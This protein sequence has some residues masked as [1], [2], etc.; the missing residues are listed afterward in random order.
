MTQSVDVYKGGL[1]NKKLGSGTATAGSATIA[2]FTS[3]SGNYGADADGP[4]AGQNI[5]VHST[6]GA[7][8]AGK[9]YAARVISNSGG[10]LVI[11]AKHPFSD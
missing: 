6:S 10:N 3:T 9:S 11:N 8:A 2:S 1:G 5:M 4:R 7:N